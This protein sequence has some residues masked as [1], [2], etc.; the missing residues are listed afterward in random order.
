[1]N[2]IGDHAPDLERRGLGD[3]KWWILGILR[4]EHEGVVAF[5]EPLDREFPIHNS[6]HYT[7]IAWGER[8]VH[9]QDI[10]G[11]NPG[12]PHRLP[13]DP[14]E[15]RCRRMLDEMLIE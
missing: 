6:N 1:M 8:T 2:H 7:A 9:D 11:V 10:A 14:D 13:R 12:L 5:G 15:E 3:R 4:H